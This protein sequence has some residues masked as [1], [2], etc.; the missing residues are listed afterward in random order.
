MVTPFK[1]DY[2]LDEKGTKF[3][4][5]YLIEKG[6]DG[7]IIG[8][9]LGEFV[10]LTVEERKRLA[11]IAVDQVKGRVPLIVGTGSTSTDISIEL[12]KHAEKI[13][14]DAAMVVLPYYW[15]LREEEVYEHFSSIAKR[16][17][18]PLVIYN[19]PVAT[20]KN[21]E[22]RL[23]GKLAHEYPNIVA[24]KD[25]IHSVKHMQDVLWETRDLDYFTVTAGME[26]YSLAILTTGGH[27]FVTGSGNFYPDLPVKIYREFKAG[28]IKAAMSA[29]QDLLKVRQLWREIKATAPA[30]IKGVAF[31]MGLPINPTTRKPSLPLNDD[32]MKTA[33]KILVE[34]GL[35]EK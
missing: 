33:K 29:L 28:N 25:S 34:A 26:D 13:G 14:A 35:L 30:I 17:N 18:I 20:G 3:L 22:P 6:V 24:F 23:V 10:E 19:F 2:S 8:G 12:T 31:L 32:Q 4:I 16:V 9:S 5:N 15:P 1:P 11:E 7:L 21:I 27:G